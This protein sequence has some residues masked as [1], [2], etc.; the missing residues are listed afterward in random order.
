VLT[1]VGYRC[2]SCRQAHR[3]FRRD[4][5]RPVAAGLRALILLADA[6]C[7]RRPR[8][9]RHRYFNKYEVP[10][11]RPRLRQIGRFSVEGLRW[12]LVVA[13]EARAC[14]HPPC[15]KKRVAV[16]CAAQQAGDWVGGSACVRIGFF[17]V[18]A[19]ASQGLA[20]P[21]GRNQRSSCALRRVECVA[22]H[23]SQPS[24]ATLPHR[25][26]SRQLITPNFPYVVDRW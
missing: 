19:P 10:V 16:V 20:A 25:S 21:S 5:R 6:C 12:S 2:L 11:T 17:W 15:S 23:L 22:P 8:G 14:V 3:P 24:R 1:R 7:A 13:A 9:P 26:S 18:V 4:H